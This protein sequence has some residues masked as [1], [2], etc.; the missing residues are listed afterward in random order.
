MSENFDNNVDFNTGSV[1]DTVSG[2]ENA[3]KKKKGAKIAAVGVGAV[4]LLAGGGI[5]AYNLS[6][7]VKNKVKLATLEPEEYYSWVTEK[8]AAESA[9]ILSKSYEQYIDALSG[10]QSS[11]VA[12][13]YEASDEV[14][15]L[16]L[17]SVFGAGYEDYA[18][19]ETQK[20]IDIV[21]N[22]NEIE[23][24]VDSASKSD[25]LTGAVYGSVNGEKLVSA[26][27]AMDY[28]ALSYYFRVPEL[29]EK[30]LGMSLEESMAGVSYEESN[31]INIMQDIMK[32][33]EKFL[34]A[35]E[36]EELIN[37][38]TAVWC[39]EIDDVELE[40]KEKVDIG[41]ITVEYTVIT[42]EID[43]KKAYEI[44]DAFLDEASDDKLIKEIVTE[45]LGAVSED[46][47]ESFFDD[48]KESLESE[49]DSMTDDDE[50]VELI[51]YVDATGTVRGMSLEIPDDD[52]ELSFVIG[53]EDDDIR[54]EFVFR[55]GDDEKLSAVLTAEKDGKTCDGDIDIKYVDYGDEYSFSVEFKDYEIVDEEK[56]YL[57]CDLTIVIP[58]VE[59]IGLNFSS[60]GKS[61]DISC[62]LNIDGADY[63]KITLSMSTDKAGD[64]SMPDV[65]NAFIID[66]ETSDEELEEYV[67]EE[68]VKAFIAELFVKLGFSDEDADLIAES[69]A[70]EMFN[71]GD[72]YD[73][74]YDDDYY[75]DYDWDDDYYYDDYDWDDDY[76]YD[77][78]D[79][80]DTVI[81][82]ENPDAANA[83][84]AE[85]GQAYINVMDYYWNAEYWGDAEDSL[86]YKAG[87]A[88]VTGD[89]KYTVSVTADTDG[90]RFDRTGDVNDASMLPDGIDYLSVCIEDGDEVCPDAI[91]TIDSV[92]IDGK[93][94]PIT[95]KNF[96]TNESWST[97]GV[98]YCDWYGDIPEDARCADGNT[99]DTTATIIDG[100][101][102]G[103]WTTIEVT[104]TV[105]GF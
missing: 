60:D 4:V 29:T 7:V 51:T 9:E 37:R 56:G 42:A 2:V 21:N 90:Y 27:V 58:D 71:S 54:G 11:S 23:I 64:V 13:K 79:W 85:S 65:S 70:A 105:S 82:E 34:T 38:Y 93:E 19:E 44:A 28:G 94:I 80:D 103:T 43:G 102:V 73:D 45:R 20:F 69:A 57:N 39:E 26:D 95:G 91:V 25:I 63:G 41:D 81:D 48:A 86:A 68:E 24:G 8:N 3:P 6:D 16:L 12:V 33:P 31:A 53:L 14:K 87:V 100:A 30:W 35:D 5:A 50:T 98:I 89:G 36:F 88:T 67:T 97:E 104:F 46:E 40:K 74:Y 72:Y 22:I 83:V 15:T 10:G 92:K 77:D 99:A 49:K 61:Q 47:Y 59:P 101:S 96:T 62:S 78:Y 66:E 1:D 52:C 17:E 55:D 84:E 32:D 75:D 18:D 76:D